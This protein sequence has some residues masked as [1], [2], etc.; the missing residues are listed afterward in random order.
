LPDFFLDA[1]LRNA[2]GH[3]C[4]TCSRTKPASKAAP[5]FA[6]E[7]YLDLDTASSPDHLKPEAAPS[8]LHQRHGAEPPPLI[9]CSTKCQ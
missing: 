7:L 1:E 6:V 4:V 9:D 5:S 2:P 8:P 3:L